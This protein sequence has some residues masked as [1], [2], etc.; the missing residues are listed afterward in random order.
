MFLSLPSFLFIN[1]KYAIDEGFHLHLV[2]AVIFSK[3]LG[4]AF[5]LVLARGVLYAMLIGV[6]KKIHQTIKLTRTSYFG[7]VWTGFL[8]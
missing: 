4:I 8:Y 5:G 7:S 6:C 3:E 2:M 1:Y